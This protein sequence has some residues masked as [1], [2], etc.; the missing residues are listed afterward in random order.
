MSIITWIMANYNTIFA[1]IGACVTCA[2]AIVK[3]CPSQKADAAL[4]HVVQLLDWVS[5][6]APKPA[7]PVDAAK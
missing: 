7:A 4:H 1:V 2:T 3:I 6:V 5:V